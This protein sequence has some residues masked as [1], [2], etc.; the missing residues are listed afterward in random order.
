MTKK[1]GLCCILLWLFCAVSAFAQSGFPRGAILD[2]ALYN[3]LP[4]KAAQVTRSYTAIPKAVSLKQYAPDPGD[5]NPYGTCVAWSSAYAARTI[6]ESIALNRTD[7]FLTTVNV[8]SPVFVYKSVFVFRNL[9]VPTGYEGTAIPWALDVMKNEGAVKRLEIEKT[10]DFPEIHL[11]AFVNQRR[12]RINDYV[13]LYNS[14]R[15]TPGGS[16]RT[17]AVKKS[18]AEGKPV[19]IG[20]NC[21]GSF[22]T[23]KDLWQPV[24][25][26]AVNY[27]GHAMCVV[28]YDDDKYGGAFEIQ[29]SWG[30]SWGNRGYIWIPYQVF[31]QYAVEAYEIIED[32][33]NYQYNTEYSGSVQIEVYNSNEGMPV[34]FSDGYYRTTGSYTSGTRFRYLMGNNKPAYVYAFAS[35]S[36]SPETTRIFPMEG[37]NVSPVLDYSENAVAFPGEHDWIELDRQSGTD[38]LVVL[39]VKEALDIDAIRE[40]FSQAQGTFPDRVARAVGDAYIPARQANYENALMRFTARSVNPRAVFGLLLAI[41]HR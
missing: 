21:P 25:S 36:S 2:E 9:G 12:Y 24:E 33:T 23:A 22:D 39:Y 3:S 13:I 34:Q 41:D 11:S 40:R 15:G 8:F 7:R 18:L 1:P 4:R 10:A 38:Y 20:M 32:L 35:D 16:E 17:L 31:N 5:Q 6:V 28:G 30:Q 29:N 14:A 19:I 26:P 27:G 37:E